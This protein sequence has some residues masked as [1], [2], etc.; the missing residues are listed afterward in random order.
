MKKL[1]LVTIAVTSI[2][3][4][5]SCN[6]TNPVMVDNQPPSAPTGV[7]VINGDNT[8]EISW[9]KN[10]ESDVA[11]YNVY[12]AL[13]YNGKYTLIGTTTNNYYD[14]NG[15]TNGITDYYAVTAYDYNGNESQLSAD[16]VSATPRPQGLNEEVFDYR[17]YPSTGGF[18]FT[19][20]SDVAYNDTTA[21]FYF[22]NYNGTFYIDVWSDTDIEDMGPTN[23]IYDI[24]YAPTSGWST[25]KDAQAIV[26]HTYVIWTWDNHY[27]KI[28]VS[29]L[30]NERMVF[31]WAFQTVAKNTQ[32]KQVAIPKV[33]RPLDLSKI[34][35]H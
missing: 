18:S 16:N 15:A 4:L 19:T 10:P 1:I 29:S 26:G 24:S 5:A 30:T 6:R 32:L 14:D 12:Y 31:D 11:G 27:A 22:E 35:R 9:N 28:R 8:V 33:R 7:Q 17:N 2:F 23:S 13:S 34:N 3:I 25:T 21:D 20:Y